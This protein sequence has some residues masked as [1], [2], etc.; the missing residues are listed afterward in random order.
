VQ[1]AASLAAAR[2]AV[3]RKQRLELLEQVVGGPE[4]T[5]M[6]IAA[7]ARFGHFFFHLLPVVAVER[8][9]LDQ[10]RVDALAA[11]N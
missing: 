9:A 8:I 4:M 6:L 3:V 1:V 7:R 2:F 11:E 10:H 5:E